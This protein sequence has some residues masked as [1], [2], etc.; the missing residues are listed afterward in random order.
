MK[1]VGVYQGLSR[2]SDDLH[3]LHAG[4]LG[5]LGQPPRSSLA[6][7]SMFFRR[8]DTRNLQEIHQGLAAFVLT[9]ASIPSGFRSGHMSSCLVRT[10][11]G[12]RWARLAPRLAWFV[13]SEG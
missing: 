6:I 3:V 11:I 2:P 8:A 10:I 1:P 4:S 9:L 13:E 7:G 12:V 5:S